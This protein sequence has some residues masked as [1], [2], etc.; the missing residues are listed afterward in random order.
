MLLEWA[1]VP[2]RRA[3]GEGRR[4]DY[5]LPSTGADRLGLLSSHRA[6]RSS[7]TSSPT[8]TNRQAIRRTDLQPQGGAPSR[9]GIGNRVSGMAADYLPAP[10]RAIKARASAAS[11]DRRRLCAQKGMKIG[12][13]RG[14]PARRTRLLQG[15]PG[16]AGTSET[17]GPRVHW[18]APCRLA[19][20]SSNKTGVRTNEGETND[21]T[22]IFQEYI[23]W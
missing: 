11:A 9:L 23:L 2:T 3:A 7:T 15:A 19:D 6:R 22:A 1:E 20:A 18:R 8:S 10:A 14:P 4:E 5:R 21:Q 13:A 17:S 16:R 12:A